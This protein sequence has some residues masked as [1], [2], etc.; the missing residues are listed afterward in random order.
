MVAVLGGL[1]VL[2]AR[3]QAVTIHGDSMSPTLESGDWAW[4]DRYAYRRCPPARNDMVVARWQGEYIVKRVVGL[5]GEE[6]A[7]VDGEVWING[8][9]SPGPHPRRPGKL[10]IDPGWLRP[11]RFALL[12]DNRSLTDAPT[13]H[14]VVTRQQIVGKVEWVLPVGAWWNSP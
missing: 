4:I 10:G 9:P 7:V 2:R 14:A 13:V 12:G 8:R 6:I 5:P 1:A 11:D 3:F